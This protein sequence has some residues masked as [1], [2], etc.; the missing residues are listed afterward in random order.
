MLQLLQTCAGNQFRLLQDLTTRLLNVGLW[1]NCPLQSAAR[2]FTAENAVQRTMLTLK[3]ASSPS[4]K[5]SQKVWSL[6]S[7]SSQ[8]PQDRLSSMTSIGW[9]VASQRTLLILDS[10]FVNV[11]TTQELSSDV[12]PPF[13]GKQFSRSQEI[14]DS[15]LNFNL[16][17]FVC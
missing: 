7:E 10:V 8:K 11:L 16:L 14:K 3:G 4:R 17:Y 1:V 6:L 5:E 15:L 12:R 2:L 9:L 13:K